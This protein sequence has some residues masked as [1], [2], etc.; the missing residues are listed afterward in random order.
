MSAP[1]VVSLAIVVLLPGALLVSIVWDLVSRRSSAVFGIRQAIGKNSRRTMA[2]L[3]FLWLAAAWCLLAY[4]GVVSSSFIPPPHSV[5]VALGAMF[6]N[7]DIAHDIGVSLYRLSAGFSAAA[8]VG[9]ALG[10]LAGAFPRAHAIIMPANSFVRYIPATALIGLFF[11]WFGLGEVSK[12]ALIF[13]GVV[14]F[15][16]Q[17]VA[18][19][20]K[21]VPDKYL[22][23]AFTLGARRSVVFW[24]VLLRAALPD[25][26]ITWR[27]E[28]AA[29]WIFLIIAEIMASSSGLGNRIGVAWRYANADDLFA[30]IVVIGFAGLLFDWLYELLYR[31]AFPYLR[32]ER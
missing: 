24:R 25:I 12:M 10:L 7:V 20:V 13:S 23:V 31:A 3:A 21:Q 9:T 11:L 29:A 8:V 19:S 1:A 30:A 14:F 2:L 22:E 28:F 27:V 26:L 16:I 6:S 4:G 5:I 15:L 32:R 17:R 18:D